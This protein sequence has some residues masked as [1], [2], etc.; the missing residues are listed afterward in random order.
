MG[1][2]TLL[3]GIHQ[4]LV[5]M[6]VGEETTFDLPPELAFGRSQDAPLRAIARG[7]FPGHA[8][9]EV[10]SVFEANVPGGSAPVQLR[11]ERVDADTVY[12][13]AFH[14]MA[15]KAFSV[16]MKVQ[17]ARA[18]TSTELAEGR[19]KLAPPPPPRAAR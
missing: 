3:P 4:R 19:A 14:P 12:V 7:E 8:A 11:V 16:T 5:G 2:A 18:A 13:R 15:D 17:R 10:G 9:P 6:S 1:G